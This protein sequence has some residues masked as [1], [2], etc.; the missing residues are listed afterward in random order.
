MTQPKRV[1]GAVISF[2][3]IREDEVGL[4][5]AVPDTRKL[6]TDKLHI[7][8]ELVTHRA[9]DFD[10]PACGGLGRGVNHETLVGE[11]L[12]TVEN[13]ELYMPHALFGQTRPEVDLIVLCEKAGRDLARR[14]AG[15]G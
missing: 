13:R 15:P 10:Q 5:H 4:L 2:G 7:D 1:H 3:Q 12:T 11:L 9:D 8:V 14:A 6:R